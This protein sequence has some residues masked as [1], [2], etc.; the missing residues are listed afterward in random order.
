MALLVTSPAMAQTGTVARLEIEGG[1]DHGTYELSTSETCYAVGEDT[2]VARVEDPT[3][4]PSSID[5]EVSG[6]G[7]WLSIAGWPAGGGYDF[8]EF[9]HRVEE[10]DGDATITVSASGP[11]GDDAVPVTVRLTVEC[12]GFLDERTGGPTPEPTPFVAPTPALYGPPPEG[13][14]TVELS[15]D[16][17]PWAGD[18]VAWTLEDACA[19]S[20]GTWMVTIHDTMAIPSHVSLLAAE[21]TADDPPV[22]LFSV[23]LGSTPERT[24]YE[25]SAA[26]TFELDPDGQALIGDASAEALLP[27][28]TTAQGALAAT[29]ACA[30]VT[31]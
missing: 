2:W 23:A 19:I 26:A 18:Y 9:E 4:T 31:P 16:F 11:A 21:A 22:G 25:T 30:S 12:R 6:F 5:L 8:W 29:I 20:D 24:R 15:L 28:G 17:G 13:S 14:S 7:S 10:A 27:D 3:S 1:P